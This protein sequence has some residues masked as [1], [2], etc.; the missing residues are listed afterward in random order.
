LPWHQTPSIPTPRAVF[1]AACLRYGPAS[2]IVVTH[3]AVI[4]ALLRSL[5][6][7]LRP[8]VPTAGWHILER[9]DGKWT[10]VATDRTAG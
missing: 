5:D 3:D 10:V 7:Q 6:P 1:A 8:A 9:D 4:R 2:V